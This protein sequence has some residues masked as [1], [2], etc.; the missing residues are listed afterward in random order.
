MRSSDYAAPVLDSTRLVQCPFAPQ[1]LSQLSHPRIVVD[2]SQFGRNSIFGVISVLAVTRPEREPPPEPEP[3][4]A[5][6]S[7]PLSHDSLHNARGGSS[8]QDSGHAQSR[9]REQ[10]AILLLRP[11]LA[12]SHREHHHVQ[13]LAWVRRVV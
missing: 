2:R 8:R 1:D 5:D 6:H 9:L 3:V 7:Q 13:N 11:F 12:T 4:H 10:R